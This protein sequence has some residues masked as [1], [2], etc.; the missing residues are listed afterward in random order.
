MI[1]RPGPHWTSRGKA[2]VENYIVADLGPEAMDQAT[3]YSAP[4][5]CLRPQ[6]WAANP[7]AGDRWALLGDAAGLVDPITGEGIYYALRSAQLLAE[8]FPDLDA[9]AEEVQRHCSGDLARASHL[10]SMFYSGSFLGASFSK[11]LVQ[12]ARSSPTI[13]R[14][15]GGLVSGT[16]RY[17]G[18]RRK[19]L[20][21]APRVAAEMLTSPFVQRRQNV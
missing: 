13:R 15:L 3:F 17:R 6:T 5:P 12:F 10:Y 20:K 16:E 4:V 11:R 1:T 19:L 18:L 8:T 14:H 21:S 7:V 2:L 9:Y